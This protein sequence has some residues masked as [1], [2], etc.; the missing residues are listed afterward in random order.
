MRD[1]D[2]LA[3]EPIGSVSVRSFQ[4][5]I[6]KQSRANSASWPAAR[7]LVQAAADGL[8]RSTMSV[9]PPTRLA[10]LARLMRISVRVRETNSS[11]ELGRLIPVS[12]GFRAHLSPARVARPKVRGPESLP[13]GEGAL[14]SSAQL[15]LDRRSR[16]TLAHEIGHTL[17][18]HAPTPTE[19]PHRLVPAG[20]PTSAEYR[21]EEGLC[22]D[23]ARALLIPSA[24][25]GWVPATPDLAFVIHTARR[26]EVGIE[27]LVRR[28]LHDWGLWREAAIVLIAR[29]GESFTAT[30]FRGKGVKNTKYVPT[31]RQILQAM[32]D[33]QGASIVETLSKVSG[34]R[35]ISCQSR[36]HDAVGLI[37]R[38]PS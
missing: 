4:E 8:L 26:L 27:P 3:D 17:F 35:L 7:G 25:R 13:L 29:P 20:S 19:I 12:G 9:R 30:V 6:L 16:F 22:H 28:I 21:R 18:Y 2:D 5:Y 33:E 1:R 34:D 10:A 23:F 32:A 38:S 37:V 15:R 11:T 36:A 14:A 31:G 24:C